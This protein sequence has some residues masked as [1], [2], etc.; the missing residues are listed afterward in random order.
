VLKNLDTKINRNRLYREMIQGKLT[1]PEN[2]PLVSRILAAKDHRIAGDSIIIQ[3]C[4]IPGK[5]KALGSIQIKDGSVFAN[6]SGEVGARIA[7]GWEASKDEK[8]HGDQATISTGILAKQ[9]LAR[10]WYAREGDGGTPNRSRIGFI[11]GTRG[12]NA[13]YDELKAATIIL[14]NGLDYLVNDFLEET[15]S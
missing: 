12:R 6:V 3:P 8:T 11:V 13:T 4:V 14:L 7:R 2:Q 1:T 10:S 15:Q 5:T 9:M